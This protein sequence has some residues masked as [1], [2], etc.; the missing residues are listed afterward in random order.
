MDE[1]QLACLQH[2]TRRYGENFWLFLI[3]K[4]LTL[5]TF[6]GCCTPQPY[7]SLKETNGHITFCDY[8]WPADV[9]H[10]RPHHPDHRLHGQVVPGKDALLHR[11]CLHGETLRMIKMMVKVM[12]MW[13]W[14]NI[15]NIAPMSLQGVSVYISTFSMTA[16]ALDRYSTNSF[17]NFATATM[18]S[19]PPNQWYFL[20]VCRALKSLRIF[21][22]LDSDSISTLFL[23]LGIHFPFPAFLISGKL[24]S[25]IF[26]RAWHRRPNIWFM[27]TFTF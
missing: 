1:L 4:T 9:S 8:I 13:I 6:W 16:I 22:E 7:P 23:R 2:G 21:V 19:V 26:T 14:Q 11:A 5:K 27:T 15:R 25:W 3:L 10:G 24:N 17:L 18:R 20:F 12:M